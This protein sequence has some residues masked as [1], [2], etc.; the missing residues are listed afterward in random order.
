MT[1]IDMEAFAGAIE[2]LSRRADQA[3]CEP[4]MPRLLAYLAAR[5]GALLVAA[6]IADVEVA[7][8][9]CAP[10][11]QAARMAALRDQ[12]QPPLQIISDASP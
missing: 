1:A 9:L 10:S 11:Q 2:A 8:G 5:A 3:K 4:V 6:A 12:L 7:V